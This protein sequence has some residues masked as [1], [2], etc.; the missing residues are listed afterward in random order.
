MNAETLLK[1][2]SHLANAPEGVKRLR[3]MILQL[4]LQGRLV[5]ARHGRDASG[6]RVPCWRTKHGKHE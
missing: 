6:V 2:F 5:C 3:E 1:N 4:G